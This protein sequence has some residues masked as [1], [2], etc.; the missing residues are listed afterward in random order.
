[1]VDYLFSGAYFP[2]CHMSNLRKCYINYKQTDAESFSF[3]FV[4]TKLC[5]ACK[6]EETECSSLGLLSLLQLQPQSS[7]IFLVLGLEKQN[8]ILEEKTFI[9]V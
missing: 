6:E 4:G 5:V 8:R 1:M 7:L 2:Q 3:V 9:R